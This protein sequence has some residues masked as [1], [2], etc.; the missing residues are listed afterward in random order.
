MASGFLMQNSHAEFYRYTDGEGNQHFVDDLSK[1]PPEYRHEIDTFKEK[2]DHLPAEQRKTMLEKDRIDAIARERQQR[3]DEDAYLK[4][5]EVEKIIRQKQ[6]AQEEYLKSLETDIMIEN[7]QILVPVSLGHAEN[8]LESWFLLD[9]GASSIVIHKDIA[10]QLKM[11]SFKQINAQVA[12]GRTIKTH[13]A[14]LDYFKIGPAM[15]Q[16]AVVAVIK[17][18]GPPTR[19][20]GLVGMS[21]LRHVDY[22]I[23]YHKKVI[24]WQPLDN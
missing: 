15:M 11:K 8:E 4:R 20:K 9:T 18:V 2:Y 16:D 24:R 17:H 6:T 5:L 22:R 14:R 1:I 7:G 12:G 13:L 21:F 19:F 3:E 23:D 10:D